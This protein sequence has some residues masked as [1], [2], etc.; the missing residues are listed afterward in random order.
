MSRPAGQ[1]NRTPCEEPP[2]GAD[3]PQYRLAHEISRVREAVDEVRPFVAR[4]KDFNAIAVC[5]RGALRQE[6]PE[7]R[8]SLFVQLQRRE[9]RHLRIIRKQLLK[10]YIAG[11]SGHQRGNA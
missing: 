6:S 2:V 3:C 10:A 4:R 11:V 8:L 9:E 5:P 1:V 7:L